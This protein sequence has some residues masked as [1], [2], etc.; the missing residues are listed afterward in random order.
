MEKKPKKGIDYYYG[1]PPSPSFRLWVFAVCGVVCLLVALSLLVGITFDWVD[2]DRPWEE[3]STLFVVG[4]T[5]LYWGTPQQSRV[6][7]LD[8]AHRQ[9]DMREEGAAV[10][11]KESRKTE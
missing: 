1:R 8:F 7:E 10:E 9:F 11:T 4:A 6:R 5:F 3:V 2:T